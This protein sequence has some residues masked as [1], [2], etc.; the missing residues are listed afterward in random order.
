[1]R[2]ER[3]NPKI[4]PFASSRRRLVQLSRRAKS[5]ICELFDV[6]TQM[7]LLAPRHDLE[8]SLVTVT[9]FGLLRSAR[10]DGLPRQ[11]LRV[12]LL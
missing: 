8:D 2:A 12:I 4:V 9:I 11:V 3:S 6:P 10:N 7:T 5:E 1:L